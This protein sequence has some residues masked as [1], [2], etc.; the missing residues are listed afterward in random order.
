MSAAEPP[1]PSSEDCEKGLISS[2]LQAPGEVWSLCSHR[3]PHEALTIP[4]HRIIY[5]TV[6]QWN[7]PG[8]RVDFIWLCHTLG[9][10]LGEVGGKEDISA[11]YDF[12]PTAANADHYLKIVL[13]K[14]RQRRTVLFS[15]KLASLCD[16]HTA[17]I[18]GQFLEWQRE[19][20]EIAHSNNGESPFK[21]ASILDY[22][23]RQINNDDT[24]LGDRYLCRGGGMFIFAPSGIGKSVI[25]VQSSIETAL[26]RNSFGI[27]PARPLRSLIVQAEDD[28]GDVIEMAHIVD[29]LQLTEAQ[30]ELVA[31][32]TW[33]EFINDRTGQAFIRAIDR[34]LEKRVTDIVWINPYSSY[35][36]NDIKDDKANALF[37]RNWLNPV[38][39]K[40]RCAAVIVAHTPKTNFRDTS[41]WKPSDWMY[42]GAG[43]AV[44]TNWARAV[45]VVDPTDTHGVFR[46]IAAKRAQRIGWK[47][48]ERFYAHSRED[49]KLLWVPAD[50]D[51]IALAKTESKRTP[52]DLLKLVPV[53]D[54]ILQ[55]KLFDIASPHFG[56]KKVRNF[57]KILIDEEKVYLHKIRRQGAKS[58]IGYAQSQ[59]TE[60]E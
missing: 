23:R 35:L 10:L 46:F 32:N 49:G 28:E 2:L 57:I 21:G 12:V 7:K 50:N 9:D 33:I 48:N 6:S 5:D 44:L 11:L 14:Y 8:E 25:V 15:K 26:G 29:H 59:S 60:N 17:D 54:P 51:Q 56:E 30:R 58:A 22:S 53:V 43:A 19:F 31:T 38:L 24:L 27:R 47:E 3:L 1:L 37:L 39:T 52:D 55:E 36:G 45:L 4:A 34:F 41:D 18:D 42:A 16:D 40:H 13:Q 20:S